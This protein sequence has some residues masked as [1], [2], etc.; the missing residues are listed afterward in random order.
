MV[1][2]HFIC[3]GRVQNCGF[4]SKACQVARGLMLTGY[5]KNNY[6]GTVE[7]EIQGDGGQIARFW[8]LLTDDPYIRIEDTESHSMPLKN[9]E[10]G[11]S[12]RY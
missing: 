1:R 5:V 9:D 12:V 11:F 6:D 4:R 8:R 10:L 3:H 2:E 7:M